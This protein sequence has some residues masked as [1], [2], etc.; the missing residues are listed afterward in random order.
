L[1]HYEAVVDGGKQ[2]D[3][4]AVGIKLETFELLLRRELEDR[5]TAPVSASATRL[6]PMGPANLLRALLSGNHRYE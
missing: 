3:A 4:D 6:D 5:A 2:S 1:G